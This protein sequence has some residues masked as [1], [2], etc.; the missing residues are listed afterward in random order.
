VSG[1][2]PV[3]GE[4]PVTAEATTE[5]GPEDGDVDGAPT[6]AADGEGE[7]RRR[8]LSPAGWRRR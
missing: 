7:Q 8:R 6:A 3:A 1:G 4:V 2:E 5:A